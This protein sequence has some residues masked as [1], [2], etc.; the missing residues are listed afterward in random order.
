MVI[1]SY[2]PRL[3]LY[4]LFYVLRADAQLQAVKHSVQNIISGLSRQ[5]IEY[6]K[7]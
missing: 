4:Q 6:V 2:I 1:F 3:R 7:N 5:K